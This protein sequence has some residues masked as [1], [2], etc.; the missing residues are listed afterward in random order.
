MFIRVRVGITKLKIIEC[1]EVS[2]EIKYIFPI[3][4]VPASDTDQPRHDKGTLSYKGVLVRVWV[5]ITIRLA[6]LFETEEA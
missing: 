3:L 6:S 2:C 5:D 1:N 4:P